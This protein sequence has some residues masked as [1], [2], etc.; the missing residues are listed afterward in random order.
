MSLPL[1]GQVDTS[2]VKRPLFSIIS[3]ST[4]VVSAHLW[5]FCP[6]TIRAL[7]GAVGSAAEPEETRQAK[8]HEPQRA[9]IILVLIVTPYFNVR[10]SP[11]TTENG[12]EFK[13][14]DPRARK[15][16]PLKTVVPRGHM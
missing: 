15:E 1:G 14:Q 6:S 7:I 16:R 9:R 3:W 5:L 4:G 11:Y 8:T 12:V 10:L 13:T 2:T